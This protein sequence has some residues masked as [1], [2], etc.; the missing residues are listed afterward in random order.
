MSHKATIYCVIASVV[1]FLVFA[2]VWVVVRLERV[3]SGP[4]F[5][6]PTLEQLVRIAEREQ[7]WFNAMFVSG[8][9]ALV[10]LAHFGALRHRRRMALKQTAL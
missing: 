7:F 10:F 2:G 1:V 5:E 4:A 8:N 9:L 6:E 3:G